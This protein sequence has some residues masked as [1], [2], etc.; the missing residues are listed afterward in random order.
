VSGWAIQEVGVSGSGVDTVHVWAHPVSGA[1]AVFL[2][3]AVMGDSRP[4]VAAIFGDRYASAG[5]HLEVNG[6]AEG[7]Y[8]VTAYA[9]N[10]VT[11]HFNTIRTTR[12]T[13]RLPVFDVQLN[14]DLPAANATVAGTF[15]IAGW[16]IEK[17]GAP[18][19]AVHVW[20]Y[21]RSGG[22]PVFV[23]A[24]SLGDARPDVGAYFGPAFA[25]A[26]FHVDVS[27]LADGDY[28]LQVFA[29]ATGASGFAPAYVL[30]ITV[31][32]PVPTVYAQIDLP[33]AGSTGAGTFRVSGWALTKDAPSKPGIDTIHIWALPVGAGSPR[34]LGVPSLGGSR[35]DVAL[36]FGPGFDSTG[37]NLDVNSLPPGTW[38]IAV[39]I[40]PTGASTFTTTKV[41]RV[42]VP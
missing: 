21:P 8:D 25:H 28:V 12:V 29:R 14:V 11:G 23:G 6:L 30:P 3:A 2:G 32:A 1:P 36:V 19:D 18:I 41:V 26:G 7:T 16:A 24:G 31:K 22:A 27:G 42:S 37:F 33:A 38:D 35:P 34:F 4:D 15:R 17:G 20:A 9:H 39:F 5:F 40:W 10:R 13:M